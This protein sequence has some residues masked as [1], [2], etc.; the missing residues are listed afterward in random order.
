MKAV[1][2]AETLV[3]HESFVVMFDDDI[4]VDEVPL[5]KQLM[6]NCYRQVENHTFCQLV[7]QTFCQIRFGT[8]SLIKHTLSM[9]HSITEYF[10]WFLATI[11][12]VE[13]HCIYHFN[14]DKMERE[15]TQNMPILFLFN[16]F[17]RASKDH[18]EF[19]SS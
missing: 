8:F 1:I 12:D 14:Q 13:S 17:L 15:L 10:G 11:S 7:F 9:F 2:R 5:T 18:L 6:N 3:G 16:R 19:Q 4:I